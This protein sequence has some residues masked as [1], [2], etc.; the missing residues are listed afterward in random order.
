MMIFCFCSCLIIC[1]MII[2]SLLFISWSAVAADTNRHIIPEHPVLLDVWWLHRQ[3]KVPS[4]KSVNPTKDSERQVEGFLARLI[5]VTGWK[6]MHRLS[7]KYSRRSLYR[8]LV[9]MT[10]LWDLG[11]I[12]CPSATRLLDSPHRL[13]EK[14]Q[15]GAA[16]AMKITRCTIAY[17]NLKRIAKEEEINN[18]PDY[19]VSLGTIASVAQMKWL[20]M[21]SHR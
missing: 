1:Q 19:L 14:T 16:F 13:N 21:L 11:L 5:P 3:V 6:E 10:I 2:F 20:N 17:A 12:Q 7:Y 8:G 18:L 9:A 15:H 4:M